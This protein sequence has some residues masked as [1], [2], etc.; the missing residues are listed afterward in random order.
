MNEQFI[1]DQAYWREW[2]GT[3]FQPKADK[4]RNGFLL[5]ALGWIAFAYL[6]LLSVFEKFKIVEPDGVMSYEDARS[7]FLMLAALLSPFLAFIGFHIADRR[8]HEQEKQTNLQTA[9]CGATE[10]R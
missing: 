4:K 6:L 2:W 3:L 10:I 7:F 5:L 9:A 1:D 8:L